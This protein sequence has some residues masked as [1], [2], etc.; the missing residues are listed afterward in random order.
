[1]ES[2]RVEGESSAEMQ[3]SSGVT[4][5]SSPARHVRAMLAGSSR[6]VAGAEIVW[7][8]ASE[9]RDEFERWLEESLAEASLSPDARRTVADG[10]GRFEVASS[11]ATE[12][13]EGAALDAHECDSQGHA[14]GRVRLRLPREAMTQRIELGDAPVEPLPVFVSGRVRLATGEPAGGALVT[15]D[16]LKPQSGW[17]DVDRP[18]S[19]WR[20]RRD[21]QGKFELRTPLSATH[22]ALTAAKDGYTSEPV[23]VTAGSRD[24]EL[25]PAP[26]AT[27][28]GRLML[29][30][31]VA[32][33]RLRVR[34]R[35]S[36]ELPSLRSPRHSP[37][38]AL[39]VAACAP[40]RCRCKSTSCR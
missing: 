10:Q 33:E 11:E 24:V 13:D 2:S 23:T 8:V 31:S 40:A 27:L 15:P 9:G 5:P 3:A 18:A 36:T 34:M 19:S 26:G 4:A 17:F 1:M 32:A 30:E 14:L 25:V 20:M 37:T 35:E 39:S 21:A 7:W 16:D 12:L 38:G 28:A 22:L 29:H 6:A